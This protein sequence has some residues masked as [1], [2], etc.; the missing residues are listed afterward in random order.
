[1]AKTRG[2]GLLMLWT[3][4]DAEHEAEFNQWYD[5]E[6]VHDVARLPGCVRGSRY[7]VL[8]GLEGD[9]SYRY[10]A[11]YEFDSEEALRAAVGSPS[12]AELIRMFNERWGA[13]TNRVR[14]FYGQIY[15]P[16]SG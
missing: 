6:H 9:T 3:D 5:D 13:H 14:S 16:V 10:L 4:V 11:L 2:I 1:M 8:D 7:R 12:F 15:P